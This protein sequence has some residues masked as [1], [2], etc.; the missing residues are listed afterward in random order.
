MSMALPPYTEY[1]APSDQCL[2]LSSFCS[3]TKLKDD[4]RL[5]AS[6]SALLWMVHL[7]KGCQIRRNFS[8]LCLEFPQSNY[9]SNICIK[10]SIIIIISQNTMSRSHMDVAISQ[11]EFFFCKVLQNSSNV[12][13]ESCLSVPSMLL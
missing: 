2:F 3:C 1:V 10:Y 5:V 8:H 4:T 7:I 13:A 9:F 6:C 11:L 12:S